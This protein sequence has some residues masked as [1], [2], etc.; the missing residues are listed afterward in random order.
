[1]TNKGYQCDLIGVCLRF[2]SS[3][4]VYVEAARSFSTIVQAVLYR[5]ML[6]L[7]ISNVKMSVNYFEKENWYKVPQCNK[8]V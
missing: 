3:K 8:F 2:S 1:M 4:L 7:E 5:P 6:Q